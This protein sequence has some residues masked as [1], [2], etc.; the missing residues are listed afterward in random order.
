MLLL[1]DPKT[2]NFVHVIKLVAELEEEELGEIRMG[3]Y[4]L[5]IHYGICERSDTKSD[6]TVIKHC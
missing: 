3:M 5:Y 2:I 6:V 1:L 4:V